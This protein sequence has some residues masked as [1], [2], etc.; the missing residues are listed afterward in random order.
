M[1]G[2]AKAKSHS[3][4]ISA[5]LRYGIE[6]DTADVQSW[7]RHYAWRKTRELHEKY[8]NK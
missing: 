6:V 4:Y 1:T 8:G 2:T 5:C 3:G 7:S